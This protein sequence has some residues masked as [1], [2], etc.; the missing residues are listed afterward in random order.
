MNTTASDAFPR[1]C[2]IM[3]L[4]T[5]RDVEARKDDVIRAME[6]LRRGDIWVAVDLPE[7]P[8]AGPRVKHF[9]L[10]GPSSLDSFRWQRAA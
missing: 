3:S 4:L 9:T 1:I 8:V 10:S 7:V 2:Q 6:I 5:D